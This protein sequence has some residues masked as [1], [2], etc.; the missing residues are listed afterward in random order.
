MPYY[1]TSKQAA[2]D[3]GDEMFGQDWCVRAHLEPYNGWV[4]V[5]SPKTLA[6]LMEPLEP[7]LAHAEIEITHTI[8]RR[9]EGYVKP[10]KVT[11]ESGRSDRAERRRQRKARKAPAAPPPPPPPPPP[12][13]APASVPG[14]SRLNSALTT[15]MKPEGQETPVAVAPPPPPPPR[16]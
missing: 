13:S 14:C 4:I 3:V 1:H 11:H 15:L 5:L 16:T 6:Y 7:I 10:A 9:P 8:R 2:L 12:A